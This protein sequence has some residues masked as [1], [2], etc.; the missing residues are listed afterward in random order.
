MRA[1]SSMCGLISFGPSAQLMPTLSSG[2]WEI[3]FQQ[4]STFWPVRVRSLPAWTNVTEAMIGTRRSPFVEQLL[5]GE[6]R[7][8]QVQDVERRLGEQDVDAAV[9][10]APRLLVI[11]GRASP[12]T[13]SAAPRVGD[14]AGHRGHA[15]GRADGPGHEARAPRVARRHRVGGAARDPCRG[16]VQ[17]VGELLEAVVGE[18]DAV[19]VEG[20]RLDDVGAGEKV[21]TMDGLDDLRPGDARGGRC[22][23]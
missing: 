23:P 2:A 16:D 20:V 13:S 19:G 7:G 17:L 5:D 21:L 12:R 22:S 9:D 6:Q 14:V 10:E 15:V 8:L 4:A 18:G 3:E 1:S 11:R